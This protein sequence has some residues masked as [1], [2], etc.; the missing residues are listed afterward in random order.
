MS[1]QTETP[2]TTRR[3]ILAGV[4]GADKLAGAVL[5]E[6]DSN[7]GR[8][9]YAPSMLS[10]ELSRPE[11]PHEIANNSLLTRWLR[12][13]DSVLPFPDSIGVVDELTENDRRTLGAFNTRAC[14]PLV[15][16][17]ELTAWIAL[18]GNSSASA[19]EGQGQRALRQA[20]GWAAQLHAAKLAWLSRMEAESVSRV[21]RLSVTGELASSIA[22]EVRSPLA[23]V[24]S[25]VQM[26]RDK[27]AP[28]GE[29]DRL[30]ST[31][32]AEVDRV[33]DVLS[34]MLML[35]R[36]HTS[37]QESCNLTFIA[38]AAV[39]FCRAY[40]RRQG[41]RLVRSGT[42]QLSVLGDPHEL[43]QV[44]INVLLNACQASAAGA[45][46]TLETGRQAESGSQ[47]WATVRVTDYGVGIPSD[48][49]SKVFEPF[50]STKPGGG[51]LG[52]AICR[53]IIE[54]HLGRID[55][56]SQVGTSTTVTIQLPLQ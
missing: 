51:G 55:L 27:D 26:V 36:P 37:R 19:L 45:T 53:G 3:S 46:V 29:H 40:A 11:G 2:D 44:L 34:R 5:F 56:A 39:D 33:D 1:Q 9:Y 28:A 52:L 22:H 15:H 50:Y 25:I 31:V 30:L 38:D 41:Q 32:I 35:G 13:N 8:E 21:N 47:P 43:R 23:A 42:E 10:S 18:V 14:V 12:V 7:T 54:R 48:E 49:L 4:V 24:R 6:L 17:G 20:H 16:D